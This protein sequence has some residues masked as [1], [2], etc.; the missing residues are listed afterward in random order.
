ML[1]HLA[2]HRYALRLALAALAVALLAYGLLANAPK[3]RRL[4]PPL[5]TH[6]LSGKPTTLADLRG[7]AAVV[8]FFASWCTPCKREAAAVARFARSPAGRGHVVAIDYNDAGDWRGFLRRY[9]W[10][11]PVF[12]DSSGATGDA[13]GIP[14]LPTV[15]FLNAGGEI[16][17]RSSG[18]QTTASLTHGLSAAA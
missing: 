14:G 8:V 5:P 18:A 11:F 2:M 4:A 3:A 6:V 10:S 15:V 12:D 17:S 9:R 1:A 16:V 7:H 13:F